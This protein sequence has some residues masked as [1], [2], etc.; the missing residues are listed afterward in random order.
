M[1]DSRFH[2]VVDAM[3]KPMSFQEIR[4]AFPMI[5]FAFIP[6]TLVFGIYQLGVTGK[7]IDL[8]CVTTRSPIAAHDLA[9]LFNYYIAWAAHMLVSIG[10]VLLGARSAYRDTSVVKTG[11][12]KRFA[13]M[14]A[15]MTMFVVILADAMH[16]KLA[17]LSHERI[18]G[19][20]SREPSLSPFFP[21][22]AHFYGYTI[23][24]PTFFSLLPIVSI[25]A[26]FWATATIVL[27]A[28]KSLAELGRR[29]SPLR[30]PS[31]RSRQ[32]DD[33][34]VNARIA[35]FSGTL[36]VLRSHA[37]ALS[38]VLVT[39]TLAT[40][41][42]LR[43][44]VGFLAAADRRSFKAVSDAI[45]LVWGVTFSLTLLALCIYPFIQLRERFS[46][47]GE[48][49]RGSRSEI[50]GQ[51]LK[52]NRVLMQVPANLQLVLSVL[53]PA[54]VAVVTNLVST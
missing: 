52:E 31:D 29:T 22:E 3:L 38:L 10:V 12:L 11:V 49:A 36:E 17:V 43:A 37:L 23:P 13:I 19:V 45:G 40:V 34:E 2:R 54:T 4:H 44:P 39:S 42:Y 27:C 15:L 28:S 30:S 26:A 32:A 21:H 41:A 33:A 46:A 14:A 51:W 24:V 50:L 35:A 6:V 20:L 18:F 5:G 7:A 9:P 1:Q 25:A 8:M 53:L 16:T 48:E 47:F